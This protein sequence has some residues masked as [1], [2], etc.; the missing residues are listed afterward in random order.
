MNH[1]ARA[2]VV[3][4]AAAVLDCGLGL[5]FAA[6]ERIPAPD[7]LYWAVTTATTV[8]Y[9][10]ISPHGRAGH[11]IAVAVMLTVVPLFAAAFSL[12]TSGLTAG[13]VRAAEHRIKKHVEQHMIDSRQ[14]NTRPAAPPPP[15]PPVQRG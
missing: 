5:W 10:D 2:L 14:G 11:L 7:G 15:P 8:G 3:I 12:F 1:H 6:A 9:G 13:H 4:G